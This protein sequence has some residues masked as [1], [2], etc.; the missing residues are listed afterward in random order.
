MKKTFKTWIDESCQIHE[1]ICFS[2]GKRGCQIEMRTQDFL[3]YT[4]AMIAAF[5]K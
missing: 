5:S 2:G 1:S 3:S 4:H